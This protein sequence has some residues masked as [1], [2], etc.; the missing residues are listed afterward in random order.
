MNIVLVSIDT[1]R[2]DHLEC[3]GYHRPTSPTLA[4]LARE[5]VLFENYFAPAIPTDPSFA[6]TFTGLNDYAHRIAGVIPPRAVPEDAPWLPELLAAAGYHACAADNLRGHAKF[7]ERGYADYVVPDMAADKERRVKRNAEHVT[8]VAVEQLGRLPADRPFFQFV[9]YWDPH[10]AYWPPPP[11]DGM[12]YDG[13]ATDPRNLSM[14]KARAYSFPAWGWI[15]PAVT[16][17]DYVIAQYD[18]EI[19]YNSEH[20]GAYFDALKARGLY[21]DTLIVVFSDHGE[22]LDKHEGFFDHHGLYDDNVHVPLIAKLPGGELAGTRV[23]A[24]TQTLDVPPTL[25]RAAG[26]EPPEAMEGLDLLALAGDAQAPGHRQ[27]FLGEGTWQVKRGVRTRRWKFIRAASDSLMHNWHA[28]ALRELYDV[29]KDPEEQTNL[30]NV[31]PLIAAELER[32]LDN[33]LTAMKEWCGWDDPLVEDGPT[34]RR[35]RPQREPRPAEDID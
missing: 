32:R 18:A 28:T 31:E 6:S 1:L 10:T 9:H 26:V 24:L 14:H 8:A 33:W 4:A 35:G 20:L 21:D 22:V 7:F 23:G 34:L 12:F 13:D 19:A 3:Y 2:A 27:L 17:M 16:D 5:G 25:L 30:A 15:D 11:Y 29:E